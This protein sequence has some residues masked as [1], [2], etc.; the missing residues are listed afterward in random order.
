MLDSQTENG[1]VLLFLRH[2]YY[3]RVPFLNG[4]PGTSWIINPDKL[5]TPRDWADFFQKE[6]IAF[7]VRSPSYPDAIR[8]PLTDMEAKGDLVPIA[9]LYVQDFQGK[10]I[11]QKR[12]EVQVTILR[13]K[14]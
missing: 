9:Q 4:D 5:Q 6:G 1:K 8:V 14:K 7:V 11:Q 10:R 12:V 2:M 3:L 13:V